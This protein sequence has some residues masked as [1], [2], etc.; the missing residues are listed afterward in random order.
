MDIPYI[1]DDQIFHTVNSFLKSHHPSLRIPI[2]IDDI[3]EFKLK[4]TIFP[5]KEL[6]SGC[7]IDGSLSKDFKTILIDYNTFEKQISRS[8]FTLAHEVGHF[9]LHENIFKKSGGFNTEKSFLSFQNNLSER[10]YKRLEI[11]AFRFGEELLY[12]RSEFQRII[13]EEV[14]KLGGL[15]ALVV[16]DLER[17]ITRVRDEF[18]VSG[19]AA[20][21]KIKRDYPEI[22]SVVESNVPF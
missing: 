5:T 21:N 15:E 11:Q 2:P 17:I 1:S 4:L 18:K 13:K 7:E 20:T 3:V 16:T 6:E 22:I 14:Q 9:I 12:P 8:R 10:D 19:R